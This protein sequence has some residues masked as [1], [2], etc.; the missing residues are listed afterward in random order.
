MNSYDL[1]KDGYGSILGEFL[2][3]ADF[4][5]VHIKAIIITYLFV[6]VFLI[7]FTEKEK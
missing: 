5:F 6:V 7:F 1:R 2:H 3:G 4:L